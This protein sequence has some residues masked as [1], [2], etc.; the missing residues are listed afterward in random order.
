MWFGERQQ[1]GGM[2]VNF[3]SQNTDP[4]LIL[5]HNDT[6]MTIISAYAAASFPTAVAPINTLIFSFSPTRY[7]KS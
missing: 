4:T 5:R 6:S 2:D 3:L 7:A 1:K